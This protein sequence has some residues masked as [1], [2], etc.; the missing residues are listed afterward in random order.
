MTE[1]ANAIDDRNADDI[2]SYG[3]S[4]IRQRS[5]KAEVER[6]RAA[7][8]DIVKTGKPMTVRQVFYQASIAGLVDKS[9]DGY[10]RVQ[11][12]LVIMRR[13]DELPYQWLADSSRWQRKPVTFNSVQE[14]LD[15]TAKFYRKSLWTGAG[16]YVEVWLEKD[17]LSGVVYPITSLYDVPL[18]VS[19]G[20]ASLSFLYSAAEYLNELDVPAFI[21]HLGDFDPS[22]VDAGRKI[23]RTLREMS[24]ATVIHFQRLAVLPEQIESWSLPT[25]PTKQTDTRAR[26]FGDV[27]VELDAIAPDRLRRLVERAI[28][29]HLPRREF[30]ILKAAEESEREL[31]HSLVGGLAR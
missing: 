12:D 25:R 17:A 6:R 27:S 21:Y 29:R 8:F 4:P 7:V 28:E 13:A 31:L 20:Y 23:E 1:I 11:N 15:D 2:K 3:T 19:K 14:A 5:T 10:R 26:H 9:E 22:G 30:E 18:M 24:P 16:C